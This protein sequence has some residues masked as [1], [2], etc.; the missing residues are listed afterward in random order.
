M[1]DIQKGIDD[2]YNDPA[3]QSA[4][5]QAIDDSKIK[6]V[7]STIQTALTDNTIIKDIITAIDDITIDNSTLEQMEILVDL[8]KNA[9]TLLRNFSDAFVQDYI[10][11]IRDD[12]N[13]V[14]DDIKKQVTDL[15]KELQDID[16][17]NVDVIK[18]ISDT[19][20]NISDISDYI[21]YGTLGPAI[22][23]GIALLLSCFGLIIGKIHYNYSL[24]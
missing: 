19:I 7:V 4:C 9:D 18:N 16:L 17:N 1:N 14:T 5:H 22:I 3:C 2:I 6:D 24:K 10:Q 13:T 20:H 12:V 23:L 21:L 8:T 11:V 15:T